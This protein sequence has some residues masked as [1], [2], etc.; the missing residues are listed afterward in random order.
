MQRQWPAVD[1]YAAQLIDA[2]LAGPIVGEYL[3]HVLDLIR[4]QCAQTTQLVDL[5]LLLLSLVLLAYS[6]LTYYMRSLLMQS[7]LATHRKLF[8][9]SGRCSVSYCGIRQR[10]TDALEAATPGPCG[11]CEMFPE[12]NS[13]TW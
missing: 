7:V 13:R 11:D 5:L 10:V 4:N 8:I 2:C 1:E 3:I 12:Q 9:Y 6:T